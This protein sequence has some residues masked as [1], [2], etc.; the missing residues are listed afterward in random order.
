MSKFKI[1]EFVSKQ[2]YE[3]Y[4]NRC[5]E[6]I[7]QRIIDFMDKLRD[8]L[9]KPITINDWLWGGRFQ[10]RGL[11]ANLDQI[12][13]DKTNKGILYVSQHTLG[14]AVDFNVKGMSNR[15]VYEY[16]IKNYHTNGYDKYITRMEHIDSAPTWIHV[17]V[18]NTGKQDLYIFK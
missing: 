6:F 9:G 8:D 10:Q 18:S 4:G 2:V 12:V 14:K 1:Q 15:E 7:D 13:K 11:R 5:K 16:I 17:D 3:K